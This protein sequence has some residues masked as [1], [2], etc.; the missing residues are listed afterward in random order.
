MAKV[1]DGAP[2]AR[3][4]GYLRDSDMIVMHRD[5]LLKTA[6]EQAL[7]MAGSGYRPPAEPKIRLL[8]QTG[9]SALKLML[10]IMKESKYISP[11]DEILAEKVAYVMTGGDIS[12]QQ[13]VPESYVL[14]LEREAILELFDDE[15]TFKRMEHMLK[16]GKALRN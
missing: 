15:R 8:G 10:Y 13:E 14:K 7:A 1:S 6:K 11:Y 4:L 12:E 2:K 5:L 9:Y 3:E 16:T